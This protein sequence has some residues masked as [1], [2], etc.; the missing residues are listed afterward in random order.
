MGKKLLKYLGIKNHVSKKYKKESP[1]RGPL[2]GEQKCNTGKEKRFI[3]I[4]EASKELNI[5]D[6]NISAICSKRK[7][8]KTATSKKDGLK[9]TFKYSD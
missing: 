8:H 1:I 6:S 3:S 9:Y 2:G 7:S 4:K 5:F